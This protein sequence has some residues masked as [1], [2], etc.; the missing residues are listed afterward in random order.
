MALSLSSNYLNRLF[1]LSQ[2]MP[3]RFLRHYEAFQSFKIDVQETAD[4]YTVKADLPGFNKS[5]IHVD[6]EQ[7]YLVIGAKRENTMH[8]NTKYQTYTER[9]FG[10]FSRSIRLANISK[11][12]I[13][14]KYEDGVLTVSLRKT[15]AS[16]RLSI[17]IE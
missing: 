11:E 1:D 10:S 12:D 7:N 9:S 5:D 8:N 15:S 17:A 3:D 14:A 6:V 13:T 2:D 16:Q 4:G